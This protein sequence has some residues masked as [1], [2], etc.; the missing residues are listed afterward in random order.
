MIIKTYHYYIIRKF[1]KKVH[2]VSAI[3]FALIFFLNIFTEIK[4]LENYNVEFYFPI[5]LTA[6]N[7]PSLVFETFPFI[8][9]ISTQLFFIDFY[10]NQELIIF[11]NFGI[12]NLKF[13]KIIS[14]ISF[15]LGVLICLLFYNL[16]ASLK[17][18]YLIFKN[19]YSKDNT[20][21]AV[22]N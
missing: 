12:D 15:G 9:F 14:I 16:S 19:N 20:Y 3:F 8:F 6:L 10:E 11:K 21:L 22:V 1:I 17:N 18:S 5:M 13:I 2:L 4:F 7:T